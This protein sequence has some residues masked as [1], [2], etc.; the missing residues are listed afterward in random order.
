MQNDEI[1]KNVTKKN[2]AQLYQVSSF[3]RVRR[4]DTKNILK[5]YNTNGYLTVSLS[6]NKQE[7]TNDRK[8]NTYSVHRLVAEAFLDNSQ[9][10]RCVNHKDGNKHNNYVTNLEFMTDKENAQ[11]ANA[12]F[13]INRRTKKVSQ[14]D[15]EG[16][17]IATFLSVVETSEHVKT[18]YYSAI[19]NACNRDSIACGYLWQ[20]DDKQEIIEPPIDG[21]EVEKFSKY[22]ITS[23]GKIYSKIYK[24][25]MKPQ[26]APSGYNYINLRNDNGKSERFL[27]HQ[28]ICQVFKPNI[29]ENKKAINH[30]NGNKSDNRVENLEWCTDS[31]NMMHAKNI[32]PLIKEY[33][34][35]EET[36]IDEEILIDEE[37]IENEENIINEL[38][39]MNELKFIVVNKD[40][41]QKWN[42]KQEKIKKLKIF[43]EE[44]KDKEIW[45]DVKHDFYGDRYQVSSLGRVR[46]TK[47]K[48]ICS[49]CYDRPIPYY[50]FCKDRIREVVYIH[51]LVAN[52]FLEN[53]NNFSYVNHKDKNYKNNNVDNLEWLDIEGTTKK[54]HQFDLDGNYI[55]TYNSSN[56]AAK[57]TN[58]DHKKIAETCRGGQK[59]SNGFIWKYAEIE[60]LHKKIIFKS[61]PT[62]KITL[63]KHF[64]NEPP[65]ITLKKK[66]NNENDFKI[67]KNM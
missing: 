58:S 24:K 28:I 50:R 42:D 59:T 3:G 7:S 13:L 19:A 41:V 55:K 23:D 43:E 18:P 53:P 4:I 8:S 62:P 66:R 39:K 15:L 38:E 48:V 40:K 67:I 32:L 26:I 14:Y 51:K 1:W 52:A 45:K 49:L 22:L 25:Y 34:K 11:H 9:N 5:P 27:L 31:E 57:L 10:L 6:N 16:K 21:V 65:K 64:K 46:T 33:M 63:K 29:D 12:N 37:D 47:T 54:V 60:E 20:Y 2:Y 44:N 17:F 30:I 56:E 61:E 35:N 36:F